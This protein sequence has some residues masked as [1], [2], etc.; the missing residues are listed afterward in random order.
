LG[1][2]PVGSGASII[3]Q[4]ESLSRSVAHEETTR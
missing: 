2:T 1:L 4:W 3:P